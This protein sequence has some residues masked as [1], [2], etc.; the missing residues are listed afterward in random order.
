MNKASTADCGRRLRPHLLPLCEHR[1]G[2]RQ[3]SRV[4]RAHENLPHS[5][6]HTFF[7]GRYR[8]PCTTFRLNPSLTLGCGSWG[9]NSVSE[10]VTLKHLLNIKTVAE[11]RNNM[12]WFSAPE[13]VYFKK[14]CLP[15]ALEELKHRDGQEKGLHRNRPVPRFS[16]LYKAHHEQTG[17]AGHQHAPPSRMSRRIRRSPAHWKAPA[18]ARLS[19]RTVIIALGGGSAMDAAKIMWVMYEHPEVDFMDMAMRF[20]DIRKR[21]Y[22]FPHMGEKAYFICRSHLGRHRQRSDAVRHHHR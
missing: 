18:D 6:Q 11:R 12:L 1:H 10:N 15:V 4:W 5:G 19:H 16:R 8:R 13:K 7:T 2:P 21:I 3:D 17:R 9:G 20:M 14:G 22:T